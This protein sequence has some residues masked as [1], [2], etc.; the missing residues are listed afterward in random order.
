MNYL[1]TE[2][3]GRIESD[4]NSDSKCHWSNGVCESEC[5]TKETQTSCNTDNTC[6]WN[7]NVSPPTCSKRDVQYCG[8]PSITTT[9]RYR[10]TNN[11]GQNTSEIGFNSNVRC[12][13]LLDMSTEE[14]SG[15][16]KG[17]CFSGEVGSTENTLKKTGCIPSHIMNNL[18]LFKSQDTIAEA[19]SH[20]IPLDAAGQAAQ[21]DPS[22]PNSPAI[23]IS[24]QPAIANEL[25][26]SMQIS[27]APGPAVPENY[28]TASLFSAANSNIPSVTAFANI[29]SASAIPPYSD[30]PNAPI[31]VNRCRELCIKNSD[32]CDDFGIKFPTAFNS[33][34]TDNGCYL[35]KKSGAS[36]VTAT[37]EVI[38]EAPIEIHYGV[39][40]YP[41]TVKLKKN[42]GQSTL[43]DNIKNVVG[44][45]GTSS[46]PLY[47]PYIYRLY[48]NSTAS[49]LTKTEF[50]TD[51]PGL[52]DTFSGYKISGQSCDVN[53]GS[54][55]VKINL[56]NCKPV[57]PP[58]NNASG[59]NDN[60]ACYATDP[61]INMT[62]NYSIIPTTAAADNN[63]YINSR[64]GSGALES[65]V[66][67]PTGQGTNCI[68]V[69]NAGD[70]DNIKQF[71]LGATNDDTFIYK[72]PL[73]S[74][75]SS[76]TDIATLI[77]ESVISAGMVHP[78]HNVVWGNISTPMHPSG[79][80]S[81]D[82][83][84]TRYRAAALIYP[85]KIENITNGGIIKKNH[86][87]NESQNDIEIMKLYVLEGS[88]FM[89]FN[90]FGKRLEQS[91]TA[92][93]DWSIVNIT[94]PISTSNAAPRSYTI[95]YPINDIITCVCPNGTPSS[96]SASCTTAGSTA[97]ATCDTGF[98][99]DVNN[100]CQQNTCTCTNGTPAT[101]SACTSNNAVKCSA[102]TSGFMLGDDSTCSQG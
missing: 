102:C 86:N 8:V 18:T 91:G 25:P 12:S 94:L 53:P 4:C 73:P 5:N 71:K 6:M 80:S 26:P 57:S 33:T 56:P 78:L 29:Q 63:S 35:M 67:C 45:V 50:S 59:W 82:Q 9:D 15:D 7:T 100:A 84:G 13:G 30:I 92:R 60:N 3:S 65:S 27:P 32:V 55:T 46:H 74:A 62:Q 51:I 44:I 68:A 77:G 70:V 61:N 64:G 58:A 52:P 1:S 11:M 21:S 89:K 31:V 96:D 38:F 85:N 36:Q 83:Y 99:V 76:I 49:S 47:I 22:L 20:A 39:K 2:C 75:S 81:S 14:Y 66:T 54:D 48:G 42:P 41:C 43:P 24:H 101:G 95:D 88:P 90:L 16:A 72:V 93:A 79:L 28:G 10:L 23:A 98:H 17:I 34:T 87:H 69:P 97:C 19:V 40:Y 37:I